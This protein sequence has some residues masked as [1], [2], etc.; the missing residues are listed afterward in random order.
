R[1]D[2][3]RREITPRTRPPAGRSPP[4]ARER[5]EQERES[6][7]PDAPRP[8]ARALRWSAG[9]HRRACRGRPDSDRRCPN[10]PT[11]RRAVR[12]GHRTEGLTVL[13]GG[14]IGARIVVRGAEPHGA[15]Q[16]GLGHGPPLLRS[17]YS[18]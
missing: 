18:G 3:V 16:V 17:G 14:P 7:P 12:V 6:A 10:P 11:L 15:Q 13:L 8:S 2:S 4:P 5:A 1:A 9:E